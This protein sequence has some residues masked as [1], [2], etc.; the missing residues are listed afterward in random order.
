MA[1][2]SRSNLGR[3]IRLARRYKATEKVDASLRSGL[4]YSRIVFLAFCA[5]TF[6]FLASFDLVA[7]AAEK[8]NIVLLFI[9]DW[10]WNGTPVPM[11]DGI[12]NASM[13]GL[14]MPNAERPARERLKFTNAYT[15]P[16]CSPT[17]VCVPIVQS[18]PRNGFTV[19][20]NDRGQ[21]Y[22]DEKGY[23]HFPVI[24]C[25]SDTTID[26]DAVTILDAL[27]PFGNVNAH[28]RK[29]QVRGAPVAKGPPE[30]NYG[31]E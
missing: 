10:A 16:Q 4:K 21:D 3:S 2:L 15:S 9:D 7:D 19:F 13:P 29:R 28:V 12:E 24:P 25:V 31:W 1:G 26:A 18:S 14:Q 11:N 27:K 5:N 6:L 23:P 17:R 20:M 22:L 8:P 30:R